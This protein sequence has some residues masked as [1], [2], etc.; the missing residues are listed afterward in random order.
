MS[1][2]AKLSDVAPLPIWNGVL[3]RAVQGANVTMAIVELEPH[4]AVPEH[5]HHNEQLGLVLQGSMTFTIG[6]E[7]RE[8]AA[9][10]VY[11]IPADV[12]HAVVTGPDGAVVIDVF[13]PVRADWSRFEAVPPQ[14]PRWP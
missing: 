5:Q 9:G 8:L 12:P 11:N 14:P 1:A 6:G 7:R 10:D 4:S 13:S 2:F 3:G